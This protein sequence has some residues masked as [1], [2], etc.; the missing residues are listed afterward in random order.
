[1][2][3]SFL[4]RGLVMV[5][6]YAYPAYECFKTVE[7]NKPEIEQLL[8]W[9][10]Y[11]ILVA[12]LTVFER[13]GDTFISWVPMYSEA[14]LA[15][16]IYLWF[17]KTKGTTYVYDS[18]FRPYLV[19]HETE[20]DRNLLEIKARAGDIAFLYWQR[21]ASYG[22]TRFFE[23]LQYVASQSTPRPRSSQQQQGA[24]VRPTAPTPPTAPTRQNSTNKQQ[25]QPQLGAGV[26]PTPPTAPTRQNSTNKQQE[27]PQQGAGVRPT[28]PT[29]PTRQNSTNKQQEQP[30]KPP[31]RT[32]SAASTEEQQH[33]RAIEE[34]GPSQVPSASLPAVV[35]PQTAAGA[36]PAAE[37][38]VQTTQ[39]EA[40]T[41]K[42]IEPAQ[43]TDNGDAKPQPQDM[44]MDEAIMVTRGR[45]R[46]TRAAANR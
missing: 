9:C 45:L 18:F 22:Q 3:G 19:K 13:V 43:S 34:A 1:M 35:R 21:A 10:Q 14:K 4:T 8:F 42:Q 16:I 31:S 7:K 41:K 24:G 27:Q 32:S 44:I 11:W 33:E 6:G 25:E 40:E 28:P 38:S 39:K 23:I 37:S 15:F 29:A 46:K 17:P 20:I 2:M 26:R 30:Q 36:E 5:F 12:M